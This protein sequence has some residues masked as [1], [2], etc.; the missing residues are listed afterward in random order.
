MSD[1]DSEPNQA[2]VVSAAMTKTESSSNLK[3]KA[4]RPSTGYT[5]PQIRVSSI[6]ELIRDITG[7][8]FDGKACLY[9]TFP[10]L[11]SVQI[12]KC[13]TRSC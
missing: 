5:V 1:I 4:Q 3:V 7:N 13:A 6:D 11:T 9:D 12:S 10:I 8:I 2:T